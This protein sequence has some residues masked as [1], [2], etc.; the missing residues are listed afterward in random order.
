[1]SQIHNKNLDTI[2]AMLDAA[3]N[4]EDLAEAVKEF[5]KKAIEDKEK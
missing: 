4:I 2:Q 1:M 5:E 3:Q